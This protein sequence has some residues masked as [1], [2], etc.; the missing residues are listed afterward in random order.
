MKAPWLVISTVVIETEGLPKVTGSHVQCKYGNIS[1]TV[2]HMTF[3]T[4]DQ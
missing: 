4:T 2:Q 3:F 1:E